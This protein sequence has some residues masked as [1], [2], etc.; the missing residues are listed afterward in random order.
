MTSFK[1]YSSHDFC[2]KKTE[3][4]IASVFYYYLFTKQPNYLEYPQYPLDLAY[5]DSL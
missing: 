3:A 2:C 1:T 4:L 5:A